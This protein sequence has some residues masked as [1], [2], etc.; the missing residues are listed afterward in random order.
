M[1]E[2]SKD[3]KGG[4]VLPWDESGAAEPP[5]GRRD[6]FAGEKKRK[7]L[8]ALAKT[9]CI[10]DACRAA[11][12]ARETAY[13]HQAKDA[14]FARH[15]ELASHMSATDVELEA[16]R[17]GVVGIEEPIFS[18]GK[19]VGT[20]IRRSDAILKVLLQGSNRKKYGPRPGFTRGQILKTER[21]QMER[22]ADRRA[23]ERLQKL[24][25]QVAQRR[26]EEKAAAAKA[27]AD[28]QNVG[29]SVSDSS[30]STGRG[31]DPGSGDAAGGTR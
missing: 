2:Q 20:R 27:A 23:Q 13:A 22:E 8:R 6:A 18:Y 21:K 11:G 3:M 26:R 17:R 16:W 25:D 7:F 24:V 12:I 5:P 31:P 28:Q 1:S 19:V 15:C 29:D 4:A 9:G 10:A 14:E 30:D